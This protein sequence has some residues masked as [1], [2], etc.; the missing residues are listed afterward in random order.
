ME[1]KFGSFIS[2]CRNSVKLSFSP[3]YF[4]FYLIFKDWYI[5]FLFAFIYWLPYVDGFRKSIMDSGYYWDY[6]NKFWLFAKIKKKEF[7][8]ERTF[9]YIQ[10]YHIK[11]LCVWSIKMTILI[12]KAIWEIF[13][14]AGNMSLFQTTISG[15]FHFKFGPR[16]SHT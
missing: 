3:V 16:L 13:W 1:I 11:V 5:S 8:F 4:C 2:V 15:L 14:N 12:K 6:L 7:T 10:F 9:L